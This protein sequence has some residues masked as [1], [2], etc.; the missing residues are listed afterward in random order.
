MLE[1]II[2]NSAYGDIHQRFE[3]PEKLSS[4]YAQT[5]N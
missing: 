4:L 3:R 1:Y 5:I 2:I